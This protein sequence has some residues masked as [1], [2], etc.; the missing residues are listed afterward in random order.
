VA[1]E[2]NINIITFV[3]V[4]EPETASFSITAEDIHNAEISLGNVVQGGDGITERGP[5]KILSLPS[6]Q[7]DIIFESE[8]LEV[9]RKYPGSS[10]SGPIDEMSKLFSSG[11]QLLDGDASSV[12]WIRY[13][14]NFI[15]SIPTKGPA[16]ATIANELFSNEYQ[17]K[18]NFDIIGAANS[19]WLKVDDA[20]LWLRI[21]PHR[22]DR[23]NER[24]TVTANFVEENGP[25]PT[26]NDLSSK[27]LSYW[28]KLESLLGRIGL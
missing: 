23:N 3:A 22:N 6:D 21:D 27:L 14:Y 24:A 5:A 1:N 19:L 7:M 13:G 4:F 17:G 25:L 26:S 8:R 11:L 2:S 9:R 10:L 18:L 16:G 20:V 15:L 12:S 28:G